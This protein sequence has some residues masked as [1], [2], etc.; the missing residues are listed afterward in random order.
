MITHVVTIRWAENVSERD[1]ATYGSALDKLAT[2]SG[3]MLDLRHGR[4]LRLKD[5][6]S[7]YAVLIEFPDEARCTAF[8]S[9]SDHIALGRSIRSMVESFTTVDF[10]TPDVLADRPSLVP[11]GEH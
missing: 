8:Y 1:I 2:T 9:D 6:G 4:N 7:D 10:F 11:I 5:G 3:R